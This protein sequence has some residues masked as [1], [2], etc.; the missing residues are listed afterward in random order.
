MLPHAGISAPPLHPRV[1][2]AVHTTDLSDRPGQ[3]AY[4]R[5]LGWKALQDAWLEVST[6]DIRTGAEPTLELRLPP[7]WDR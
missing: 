3:D 5:Q 1:R 2:P 6:I 4:A 7:A